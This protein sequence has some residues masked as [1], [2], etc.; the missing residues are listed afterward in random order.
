[1][2]FGN[3]EKAKEDL[4]IAGKDLREIKALFA[5]YQI[6]KWLIFLP[7]LGLSTIILT[8]AA[9]PIIWLFGERAGQISGILW[10]RFNSFITPMRMAVKGGE[11]IDPNQ[12]YVVVANH[13]SQFDIFAIYGWLPLDFRW[14]MKVELRKAP[15][16]GYYCYKAGH[17]FINRSDHAS[18]LTSINEAKK[19]ITGGTSIIF[20][21]EGTR[22]KT[23]QLMDF[24]KGAFKFA[25]DMQL[26]VLPVTI[27][28][29]KDILPTNTMAL[30]PGNA[31]MTI[32]KPI[33]TSAYDENTIQDLINKSRESIQDGLRF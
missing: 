23:G 32:H 29:T 4:Y 21:P 26:P 19:R 25:L 9:V 12:S 24:K 22:S 16:L 13:Q 18:A 6:Y 14:V 17:V 28:G 2:K 27:S 20:F 30:F 1:M 8:I 7:L 3:L 10:A 33:D 31:T 11:N 5:V 15:V